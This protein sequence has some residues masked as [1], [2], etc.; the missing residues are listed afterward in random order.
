MTRSK[1]YR[2]LIFRHCIGKSLLKIMWPWHQAIDA[3]IMVCKLTTGSRSYCIRKKLT[4]GGKLEDFYRIIYLITHILLFVYF[5]YGSVLKYRSIIRLSKEEVKLHAYVQHRLDMGVNGRRKYFH[6][7]P[8]T[9]LRMEQN[10]SARVD[11]TR[12][13]KRI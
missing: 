10:L 3:N 13:R 6:H 5:I 9:T 1:F 12:S 11:C 8:D 2:D 7:S 4:G